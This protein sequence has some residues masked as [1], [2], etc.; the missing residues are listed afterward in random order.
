MLRDDTP[1][2]LNHKTLY[3]ATNP[4]QPVDIKEPLVISFFW[5]RHRRRIICS[6]FLSLLTVH[7]Q[8][9]LEEATASPVKDQYSSK[10]GHPCVCLLRPCTE[11]NLRRNLKTREGKKAV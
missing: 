11:A 8:Y 4:A 2:S 6:G 9:S 5:P 10:Q 3:C 7:D 1:R